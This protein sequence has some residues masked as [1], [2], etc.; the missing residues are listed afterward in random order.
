MST[1]R[2]T[3]IPPTVFPGDSSGSALRSGS[4]SYEITA[5][6]LVPGACKTLCAP[7]KGGVPPPS[8]V[9]LLC[10]SPTGLQ[11]QMLLGFFSQCPGPRL[12]KLVQGSELLLLWENV[13]NIIVLQILSVPLWGIGV[14]LHCYCTLSTISLWFLL[15]L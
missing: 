6:P 4:G 9:Q 5:F 11:S 10:S 15:C 12:G 3:T 13:C 14:L 1:N 2:T 8:L 7:S